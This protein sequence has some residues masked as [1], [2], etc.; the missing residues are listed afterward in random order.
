MD[1][2]THICSLIDFESTLERF[3]VPYPSEWPDF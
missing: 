2:I 1:T 3:S